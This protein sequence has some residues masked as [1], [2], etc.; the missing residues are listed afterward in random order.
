VHDPLV[1]VV[2]GLLAL[3]GGGFALA[4]I[5]YLVGLAG[6]VSIASWT[7]TVIFVLSILLVITVGLYLIG[8]WIIHP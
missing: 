6:L 5:L 1:K 3:I 7:D 8:Y 4:I 2:I